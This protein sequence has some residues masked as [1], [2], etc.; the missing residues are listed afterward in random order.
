MAL[1][2]LPAEIHELVIDSTS[3]LFP[4][5]RQKALA[6]CALVCK[7]WHSF[8][9]RYTFRYIR[10]PRDLEMGSSILRLMERNPEIQRCIKYV[11]VENGT[12]GAGP[13]KD[14]EQVCRLCTG[15]SRLS[16]GYNSC[17][18]NLD[19]R[20][21]IRNGILFLLK[22]PN[23]RHLSFS[24]FMFE[25]SLLEAVSQHLSTLTFTRVFQVVL[26]HQDSSKLAK[27]LQ[28]LTFSHS[29]PAIGIMQNV[30]GLCQLFE[31]MQQIHISADP[32]RMHSATSWDRKLDWKIC[33]SMD[34]MVRF[35]LGKLELE[36]PPPLCNVDDISDLSFT[37]FL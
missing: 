17:G 20:P 24:Y 6:T 29:H 35:L 11:S 25:T 3:T 26:D 33:T 22:S 37:Y 27:T 15:V 32:G 28:R 7:S 36:L 18:P 30:P 12:S 23:L 19:S 34:L 14:F 21:L 10:L 31:R 8:T 13:D 4:Q 1:P 16:L 5:Y 2:T 9:L